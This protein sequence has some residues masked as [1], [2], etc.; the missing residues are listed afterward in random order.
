MQQGG[1]DIKSDIA[2][3]KLNDNLNNKLDETLESDRAH[4]DHKD[5][6]FLKHVRLQGIYNCAMVQIVYIQYYLYTY[7]NYCN[8]S[9]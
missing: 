2:T 6:N 7:N 5:L 4:V 1:T 9:V 3:E 8:K